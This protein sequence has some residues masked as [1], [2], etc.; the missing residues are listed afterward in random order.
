MTRATCTNLD[1]LQ[2]KRIGDYWNVDA[3][4]SLSDSWEGFTKCTSLNEKPPNDMWSAGRLTK[5]QATTRSENLWLGPKWEKWTIERSE[6]GKFEV[7]IAKKGR[8]KRSGFQET[9]AKSCESNNIPKTKHASI[10]EAHGSTRQRLE[11]PPKDHEDHVAGKGHN[12]MTHYNFCAQVYFY[13]SSDENSGFE[14]SS[15]QGMEDARHDSSLAVGQSRE[16]QGG[17]RRYGVPKASLQQAAAD[18]RASRTCVFADTFLLRAGR[19]N[20][21]VL[22]W[23]RPVGVVSTSSETQ[24]GKN[25]AARKGKWSPRSTGTPVLTYPGSAPR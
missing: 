4:R 23:Y 15:G 24:G 9:E 2:E 16:Q 1:V 12:S 7:P 25:R 3:N 21:D 5:I 20:Q 6:I 10:V 14:R 17:G 22:P 11:S 18:P 13:A 19:T 8:K